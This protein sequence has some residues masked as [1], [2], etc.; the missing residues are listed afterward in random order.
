MAQVL[1]RCHAHA[2]G[3]RQARSTT[4][5]QHA[6]LGGRKELILRLDRL[7]AVGAIEKVRAIAQQ[8]EQVHFE[9]AGRQPG[10]GFRFEATKRFGQQV[11]D[12]RVLRFILVG[13]AIQQFGQVGRPA[14]LVQVLVDGQVSLQGIHLGHDQQITPLRNL[15]GDARERFQVSRLAR[16]D[17]TGP[18]GNDPHLAAFPREQGK[19]AVRLAPV[20]KPAL[21]MVVVQHRSILSHCAH[22]RP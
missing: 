22:E 18:L 21:G 3:T 7:A 4:G 15:H 13:E 9:I 2:P 5:A 10:V 11:V 1:E 20:G 14:G 19:Q 8:V 6:A 17:A 16:A 12:G